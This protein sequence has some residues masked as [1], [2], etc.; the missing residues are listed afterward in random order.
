MQVIVEQ[1]VRACPLFF[2]K[3]SSRRLVRGPLDGVDPQQIMESEPAG[4]VLGD[5]V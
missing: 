5:Q 2:V 4:A 3:F 1:P